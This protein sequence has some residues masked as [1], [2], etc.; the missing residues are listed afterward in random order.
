MYRLK[1]DPQVRAK[2]PNYTGLI[3]YATNLTNR[4]SD[5]ATVRLLRETEQAKRDEF[6]AEKPTSHPHIAAWREA[7]QKFGAKPSKYPCSV[8]ALLSRVLKGQE[9]PS[10]NQVADLYN[11]VSLKYVLPL[12]GEDWDKLTGDLWLKFASGQEPF[13]TF[14][15][16]AEVIDHPAPGEVIW[17]D[18]TGATCRAWNWRQGLR[19]R[20]TDDTTNAYFV[21][22][23]MAP[24]SRDTLLK[25]AEELTGYLKMTSP[26]CTISQEFLGE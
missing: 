14:R 19:T 1:I 25:V 20:L 5:E 11:V 23:T 7:Y 2:F 15:E 10:I 8:E 3:I 12:G 17:A 6:G 13:D 16:G 4:P 18:P 24:F 21:L 22:D 26:D 9:L